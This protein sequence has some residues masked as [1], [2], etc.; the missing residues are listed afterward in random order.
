MPRRVLRAAILVVCTAF[1]CN[2]PSPVESES[3]N[4]AGLG[5]NNRFQVSPL[6]VNLGSTGTSASVALTNSTR[7]RLTWTASESAGWL[8]LGATSGSLAARTSKALSMSV[9]RGSLAPGTYTTKVTFSTS[10]GSAVVSVTMSVPQPPEKFDVTPLK[11]DFGT[12]STSTSVTLKNNTTTSLSWTAS[13][14]SSWLALGATSGTIAAGSSKTLSLSADRDGMTPGTYRT[15]LRVSAGTAGADTASVTLTVPSATG[16]TLAGQM[17]HQ[18]NGQGLAGLTVQYDGEATTTDASGYFTILGDAT[19]NL[20]QLTISGAGIYK[21]Q[22]FARTGDNR[23]RVVPS[24]FDMAAFNDLARDEFG[25][26]TVRWVTAPTVY[27]DSRPEGF[28][29]PELSTWIAEVKAQVP[30]F[31]SRWTGGQMSPAAI[32]VT[33]SPPSDF[34]AGTIVI[35]FSENA[36]DYEGTASIGY[37]R[38]AYMGNGTLNGAAVWL[39]YLAYSGSTKASK[40]K[41]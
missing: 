1:A 29:S 21:R 9:Q 14:S 10:V 15:N 19:S 33:S 23:W 6:D 40:R 38:L 24:A 32:I 39:R 17:I 34:T 8:S 25:P 22:T 18:F 30:T 13:E 36:A 26:G 37:A 11:V 31:I 27:I 35:H 7:K 4:L 41:G 2:S 12:S 3:V 16:V 5:A 20:Q 28:T